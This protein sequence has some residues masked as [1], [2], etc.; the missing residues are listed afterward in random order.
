MSNSIK[1]LLENLDKI[2]REPTVQIPNNSLADSLLEEWNKFQQIV[3]APQPPAQ[4]SLKP[5]TKTITTLAQFKTATSKGPFG[6][7]ARKIVPSVASAALQKQAQGQP[8]TPQ[9]RMQLTTVNSTIGQAAVG[10][11]LNPLT[12]TQTLGAIRKTEQARATAQAQAQ[13]QAQKQ[14]TAQQK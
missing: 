5:D 12:G 14:Q 7:T 8:L 11:L 1:N 4:Q 3:E 9:D 10:A 6:P 2:D 13:A